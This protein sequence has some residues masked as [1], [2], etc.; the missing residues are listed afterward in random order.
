MSQ[1]PKWR[2]VLLNSKDPKKDPSWHRG[3]LRQYVMFVPM[4]ELFNNAFRALNNAVGIRILY[5]AVVHFGVMYVK[6]L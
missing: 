2:P 3:N 4:K 6:P 5:D 1:I